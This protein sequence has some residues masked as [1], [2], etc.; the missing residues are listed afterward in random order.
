MNKIADATL[1]DIRDNARKEGNSVCCTCGAIW[2]TG[3]DG[4]HICSQ[5]MVRKDLLRILIAD[6]NLIDARSAIAISSIME[7]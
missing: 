4:S 6:R 2:K 1:M 3:T 7:L 5:F